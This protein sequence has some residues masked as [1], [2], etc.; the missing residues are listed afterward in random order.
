MFGREKLPVQNHEMED[1]AANLEKIREAM[2][3]EREAKLALYKVLESFSVK[4]MINI[5]KRGG[6]EE[7]MDA[8]PEHRPVFN[9]FMLGYTSAFSAILAEKIAQCEE[10]DAP[11]D[12]SARAQEVLTD[13]WQGRPS[14]QDTHNDVFITYIKSGKWVSGRQNDLTQ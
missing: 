4:E 2:D 9:R 14:V 5:A 6:E 3:V 12:Y 8:G 1:A 13:L 7:P 11:F 10:G